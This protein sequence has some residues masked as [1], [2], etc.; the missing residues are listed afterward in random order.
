MS[1]S[2]GLCLFSMMGNIIDFF[3]GIRFSYELY[4]K[5]MKEE[6]YTY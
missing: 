4:L 2:C 1:I 6:L 3:N 5:L